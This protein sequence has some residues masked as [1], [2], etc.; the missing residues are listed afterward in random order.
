MGQQLVEV[1]ALR[2]HRS[3][4]AEGGKVSK[5]GTYSVP[6]GVVPGLLRQ[7][8]IADPNKP[9]KGKVHPQPLA[10]AGGEPEGAGGDAEDNG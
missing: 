2:P 7:K 8:L 6:A 4:Y 3:G 10:Q 9:A 1:T 5:D